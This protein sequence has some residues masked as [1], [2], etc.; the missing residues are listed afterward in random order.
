[1]QQSS[2]FF[3]QIQNLQKRL[4]RGAKLLLIGVYAVSGLV[5]GAFLSQH[6][7]PLFG[8][9]IGVIAGL[10]IGGAAQ[11]VRGTVVFFPLLN[12]D[13]PSLS[14]TTSYITAVAFGGLSIYEVWELVSSVGLHPSVQISVS[15][16]MFSGVLIEL[17]I[18]REVHQ[19]VILAFFND[20]E[21]VQ[22]MMAARVA[23][24]NYKQL[25]Q[26]MK[27][28]EYTGAF[29]PPTPPQSQAAYSG[30][31][32]KAL[33]K[34][35][36]LSEAQMTEIAKAHN[37]GEGDTEILNMIDAYSTINKSKVTNSRVKNEPPLELD[38]NTHSKNGHGDGHY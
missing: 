34:A 22:R 33:G 24:M 21:K 26:Q 32:V 9:I 23:Q 36:E 38:L 2:A 11:A 16:L 10:L 31:I 37:E 5:I 29:Q 25:L 6:F 18:I 35:F 17:F 20:K 30:P 15:V 28:E 13:R 8:W 12:P 1:M 4:P 27:D 7:Y 3:K 19:G 14:A